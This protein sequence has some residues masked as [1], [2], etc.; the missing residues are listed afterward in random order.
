MKVIV[1]CSLALLLFLS[2]CQ[3]LPDSVAPVITGA[4]GSL[5]GHEI[6]GGE[7]EGAVLGAAAGAVAGTAFNYWTQ[8]NE[9]QAYAQGYQKGQSD[10]V[11][12]LYW[13]S[14]RLHEGDELSGTFNRGYYEIPVPE[15]VTN[16]GV[17]VEAHTQ[18]VE[19]IEP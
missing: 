13:A 14:K 19:V 15:H 3:S 18:V 2:A 6:S 4:A 16:D 11:K 17:I 10:E 5:I 12:R 1:Y 9:R 8:S 7:A